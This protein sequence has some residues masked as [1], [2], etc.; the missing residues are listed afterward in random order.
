MSDAHDP[1]GNLRRM[2]DAELARTGEKALR[3]HLVA[4]TRFPGQRGCGC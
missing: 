2:S 3:D 4:E 1:V